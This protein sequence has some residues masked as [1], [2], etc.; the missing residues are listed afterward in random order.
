M[1]KENSC[2]FI[3]VKYLLFAL[4]VL[5]LITFIIG[6]SAVFWTLNN[7]EDSNRLQSEYLSTYDKET[8]SELWEKYIFLKT[9]LNYLN[10]EKI[11]TREK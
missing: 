8:L 3:F 5:F 6:I 4:Y 11:K 2:H 7:A 9:E 10:G 1:E